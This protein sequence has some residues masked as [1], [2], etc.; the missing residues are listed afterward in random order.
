MSA[1]YGGICSGYFFP[2]SRSSSPTPSRLVRSIRSKAAVPPPL[3]TW[4]STSAMMGA[5]ILRFSSFSLSSLSR[6]PSAMRSS[7]VLPN[8]F[9]ERWDTYLIMAFCCSLVISVIRPQSRIP[10]R[11]SFSSK[12]LPG[13]GSLCRKPVSRSCAR[14][15]LR[16]T[17]MYVWTRS[18]SA[19]SETSTLVIFTPSIHW[20]TSVCRVD[21]KTSGTFTTSAKSSTL[22]RSSDRREVERASRL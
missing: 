20:V 2:S 22:C 15:T 11:P 17:L 8:C 12:K 5:T 18:F 10:M 1:K 19:G 7:S 3:L 6:N 13:C 9:D 16:R 21:R 14:Y 4:L